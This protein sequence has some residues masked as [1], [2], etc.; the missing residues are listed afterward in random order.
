MRNIAQKI[1]LA[2]IGAFAL[3]RE[4]AEQVVNEMVKKGQVKG[5]DAQ[6][7]L[8]DLMQRGEEE[9]QVLKQT[10]RNEFKKIISEL[11]LASRDELDQL[12]ERISRLE[13]KLFSEQ[14]NSGP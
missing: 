11:N 4:K 5:D 13:Q 1:L 8:E 7:V 9:R 12:A 2:G 10:I 6:S 14:E 3:T